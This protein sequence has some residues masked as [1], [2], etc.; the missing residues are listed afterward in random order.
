MTTPAPGDFSFKPQFDREMLSDAYAAITAADAWEFM[1]AE[2]PP[3][4]RGYM[5]WDN[6]KL[7]EIQKLMKYDGHSGAS[8]AFTMRHMQVIA[9]KGWAA[10]VEECRRTAED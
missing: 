8:Y 6:P 9:Q 10:Y 5:F 3:E 1:R 2:E 7:T 4:N